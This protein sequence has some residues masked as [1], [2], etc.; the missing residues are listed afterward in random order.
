MRSCCALNI[1]AK[2]EAAICFYT[3]KP[4]FPSRSRFKQLHWCAFDNVQFFFPC[5][6]N[7]GSKTWLK[8]TLLPGIDIL[9]GVIQFALFFYFFLP[10]PITYHFTVRVSMG[11]K[12]L[13]IS[14]PYTVNIR[15]PLYCGLNIKCG[16]DGI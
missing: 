16:L 14:N 1:R 6:W 10:H 4:I 8:C 15:A 11:L 9:L 12:V 13:I 5:M 3:F 7:W 2:M